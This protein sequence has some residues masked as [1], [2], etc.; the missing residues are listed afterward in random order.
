LEEN[1]MKV[2]KQ[3][4]D[5]LRTKIYSQ[6]FDTIQKL[7]LTDEQANKLDLVDETKYMFNSLFEVE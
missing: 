7:N 4:G 6:L 1:K 3:Q 2:T 5:N